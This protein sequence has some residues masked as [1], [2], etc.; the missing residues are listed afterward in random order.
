MIEWKQIPWSLWA[1]SA[2]ILLGTIVIEV[3]AHG[4][5]PAKVLFTAVMLA[6]LYF[7][8]KGM[9]WLWI[10]TIGI[11]VVGL[12]LDVISGSLEWQGLALS[13]VSLML[14]LLPATR[15]YFSRH[16]PA[17]GTCV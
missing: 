13:V 9:R 6:W 15:R 12:I 10:V 5:I 16:T 8:L 4:P 1:Y 3:K 14:L 17:A 7:L 2:I 11:Y